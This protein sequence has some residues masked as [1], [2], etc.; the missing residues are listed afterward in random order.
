MSRKDNLF[1]GWTS[2]SCGVRVP[3]NKQCPVCA[4]DGTKRKVAIAID[5][6]K[7]R[8]F[9]QILTRDNFEFVKGDG[10]TPDTL[11]LYVVTNDIAALK[12]TVT[13][14]NRKCAE[15]KN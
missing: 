2:C 7:L 3:P 1:K 6:W 8:T 12:K 10:L 14:A 5:K 13:I 9:V 11:F 15:M 4:N